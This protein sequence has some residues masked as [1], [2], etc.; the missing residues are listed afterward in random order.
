MAIGVVGCG[1]EQIIAGLVGREGKVASTTAP[2]LKGST[3]RVA[4]VQY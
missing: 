3:T 2:M 1:G 4:R